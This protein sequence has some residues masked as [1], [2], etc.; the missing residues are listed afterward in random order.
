MLMMK[1]G[2]LLRYRS[3]Q[4]EQKDWDVRG[5]VEI[6]HFD[7]RQ[8]PNLKFAYCLNGFRIEKSVFISILYSLNGIE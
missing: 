6:R 2:N 8:K 7:G 4:K 1:S 5:I 3:E